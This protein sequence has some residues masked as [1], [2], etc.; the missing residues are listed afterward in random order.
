MFPQADRKRLSLCLTVSSI[1]AIG[2]ASVSWVRAAS[3]QTPAASQTYAYVPSVSDL[4]LTTVQTRHVR[5]WRAGQSHNWEFAE[6]ELGNLSGAFRRLGSAHPVQGDIPLQDLI[7]SVTQGPF[8]DLKKAIEAKDAS[9]FEQAYLGLTAA[10]N[11][12]HEAVNHR[13]VR[14]K[15]PGVALSGAIDDLDLDP[16]EH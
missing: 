8:A 16:A 7:E 12:C 4:M 11:T 9:G 15:V 6:Y 3:P 5:L 2:L 14:I 13:A 1:M 10:C